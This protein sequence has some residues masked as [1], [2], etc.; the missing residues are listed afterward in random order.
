MVAE[1]FVPS[2]ESLSP[3]GFKERNLGCPQKFAGKSRP[4]G[5][6]KEFVLKKFV[7]ISRSLDED[8]NFSVF[9]VR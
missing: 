5:V 1:K 8:S 4:W 9:R 2:L 3:L 6:F 7:C